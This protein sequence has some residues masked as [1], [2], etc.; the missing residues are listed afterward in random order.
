MALG[1]QRS[2]RWVAAR[3][4][5]SGRVGADSGTVPSSSP[6]VSSRCTRASGRGEPS[7]STAC[8]ASS[9]SASPGLGRPRTAARAFAIRVA[10][11]TDAVDAS[12]F[13]RRRAWATRTSQVVDTSVPGSCAIQWVKRCWYQPGAVTPAPYPL[14]R[15]SRFEVH[16][17]QVTAT[18]AFG[19]PA[20]TLLSAATG[21]KP[22]GS[23]AGAW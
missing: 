9:S 23:S 15:L 7:H 2:L 4:A 6:T 14:R 19:R 16:G 17:T 22:A 1:F 11:T 8:A 5:A 18:L 13:S 10:S 21:G 3:S 20:S 12:R